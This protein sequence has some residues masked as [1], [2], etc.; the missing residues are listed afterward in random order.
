MK[1]FCIF[2]L[3]IMS[4]SMTVNAAEWKQDANGWKYQNDDGTFKTGWHNDIDGK[5]YYLDDNTGY[6]LKNTTTPDGYSLS[7]NGSW[8]E[9]NSTNSVSGVYENKV[10]LILT[11][12]ESPYGAEP[13][14]YS[15]PVTIHYND[16]YEN[17]YDGKISNI[18]FEATKDGIG[19]S[20]FH[21][22]TESGFYGIVANCRYNIADGTYLDI[23]E[24][25]SG[26][27]KNGGESVSKNILY[28]VNSLRRDSVKLTPVSVEMWIESAK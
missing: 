21:V 16:E 23:Q 12:E 6:M 27:C 2:L 11:S 18:K 5:W 7:E 26:K 19:Y 15:L 20:S 14:G 24:T 1:K 22:N 8:R 17:I 4:F 10:D 25:Y 28:R 13:L 9:V 3:A